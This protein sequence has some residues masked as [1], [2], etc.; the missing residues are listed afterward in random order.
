MAPA[1]VSPEALRLAALPSRSPA[2]ASIAASATLPSEFGAFRIHVFSND[3]DSQEHVALVHGEVAGGQEV[4]T[5]LHSECLTG[6]VLGSLRCD[7]RAQLARALERIARE[8]RGIVLYLRQEGRGIGLT[9]KIRAYD[10]QE[11][12]CDTVDANLALGFAADEREYG[13]AAAMLR[14]L[15]VQSIALMTN[16]PD[17]LEKLTAEGIRVT[18][19]IAHEIE[20]NAHNRFYL[21]TKARRSGHYIGSNASPT[22]GADEAL[23]GPR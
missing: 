15:G 23:R 8:P 11:R 1:P 7:C 16:N 2:R 4:P 19:R 22:D 5:R 12:G 17:K 21:A 9:N 6:D 14:A 18:R 10:L 13:A 3:R 20:P